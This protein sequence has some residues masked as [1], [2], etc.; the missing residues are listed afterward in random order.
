MTVWPGCNKTVTTVIARAHKLSFV[1]LETSEE[2]GIS[3]HI[4]AR[5]LFQG[6]ACN[7]GWPATCQTARTNQMRATTFS[8]A[9]DSV[10]KGTQ[11]T[12]QPL[13]M[14]TSILPPWER[15]L[16]WLKIPQTVLAFSSHKFTTSGTPVRMSGDK[17]GQSRF[18]IWSSLQ[19]LALWYRS[20]YI[21]REKVPMNFMNSFLNTQ[22]PPE[23][24]VT[25]IHTFQ[26]GTPTGRNRN[27]DGKARR[28]HP[29]RLP[30]RQ[31]FFHQ[32]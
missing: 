21:P 31:A 28:V 15:F 25:V 26:K 23:K 27:I 12:V 10:G 13:L 1:E 7:T 2:L 32:V 16:I 29:G 18:F 19:L 5:V 30:S 20:G 8:R 14:V 9:I 22:Q 3:L 4:S 24:T 6:S 17:K 11:A